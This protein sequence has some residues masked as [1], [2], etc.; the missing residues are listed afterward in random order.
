M[1]VE[2]TKQTT[3]NSLYI[4]CLIPTAVVILVT[5]AEWT[6]GIHQDHKAALILNFLL[7]IR[8][9]PL[10]ITEI[11]QVATGIRIIWLAKKWFMK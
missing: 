4:H 9:I 2:N 6:D 8:V 11:S 1:M 7:K 10:I 3:N 5:K